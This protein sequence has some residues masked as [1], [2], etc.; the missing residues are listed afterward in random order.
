MTMAGAIPFNSLLGLH[1]SLLAS[2]RAMTAMF[3]DQ[4][5][6]VKML[7]VPDTAATRAVDA[8]TR[9]SR[10]LEER[11]ALPRAV[12][13]ACRFQEEFR[14]R[15]D[16]IVRPSTSLDALLAPAEQVAAMNEAWREEMLRITDLSREF[17]SLSSAWPSLEQLP[18]PS[19]LATVI[20]GAKLFQMLTDRLPDLDVRESTTTAELR[21]HLEQLQEDIAQAADP[22]DWFRR[23]TDRL[24][25]MPPGVALRVFKVLRE[26]FYLLAAFATIFG[27]GAT[28]EPPERQAAN[29]VLQLEGAAQELRVV[30]APKG[31][32]LRAAPAGDA[33]RLALMPCGA[34]VMMVQKGG[35]WT[36][37][38]Y[39]DAAGVRREGWAAS[40]YLAPA[41]RC[42]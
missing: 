8:M 42:D 15:L 24:R 21:V 32:Y 26:V 36:R 23:A 30:T 31:L 37:V 18:L 10:D 6:L 12:A 33:K 16:H 11:L 29:V 39:N 3:A 35:H 27:S 22:A 25:R 38:E 1:D 34:E 28:R 17:S 13:D 7:L 19:G 9:W 40:R 5:R 4:D 2:T 41:A 20:E 14:T